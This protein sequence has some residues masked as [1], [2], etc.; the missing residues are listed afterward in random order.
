MCIPP[1]FKVWFLTLSGFVLLFCYEIIG[2]SFGI[3]MILVFFCVI[4]ID[5]I[6]CP[7]CKKSLD[8]LESGI[9]FPVLTFKCDKCGQNLMKRKNKK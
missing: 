3:S 7:K 9:Y 2:I 1:F 4:L 8:R 6:R 5:F